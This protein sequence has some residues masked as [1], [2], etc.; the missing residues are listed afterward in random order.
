LFEVAAQPG[1]DASSKAF[2]VM[3]NPVYFDP[4]LPR[5]AVQ[6]MVLGVS[7][8][9]LDQAAAHNSDSFDSTFLTREFVE[10]V[11]WKSIAKTELR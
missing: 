4:T 10:R 1:T 7:G 5:S 3:P 8:L 6:L 9:N 11:D 2:V